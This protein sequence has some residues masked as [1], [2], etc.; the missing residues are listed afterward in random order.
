LKI[1]IGYSDIKYSI[2]KT[3]RG[4]KYFAG[5]K[6]YVLEFESETNTYPKEKGR[7]ILYWYFPDD[8]IHRR[9]SY[10]FQLLEYWYYDK[11]DNDEIETL[12]FVLR[13]MKIDDSLKIHPSY[14]QVKNSYYYSKEVS[15]GVG[16]ANGTEKHVFNIPNDEAVNSVLGLNLNNCYFFDNAMGIGFRFVGYYKKLQELTLT[17]LHGNQKRVKYDLVNLAADGEFKCIFTQG[18]IKPYGFFLMGYSTGSISSGDDKLYFS[19]L[20][21]GIGAGLRIPID[22]NWGISVEIFG[23]MG[24][25]EWEEKPFLNSKGVDF[26]PSMVG[27][28]LN[29]SHVFGRTKN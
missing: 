23:I 17:D 11:I 6:F 20:N 16:F 19:G 27:I 12:Y 2:Y 21:A 18:K 14:S 29:L 22:R 5:K 24:T 15:F 1:H 9:V 4:I 13:D 25:A 3:H 10:G 7:D 26:N 8:F 28:L